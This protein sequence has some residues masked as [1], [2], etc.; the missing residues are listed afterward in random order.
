MLTE[1]I[2]ISRWNPHPRVLGSVLYLLAGAGIF[3]TLLEL[4]P[5]GFI[6]GTL[7]AALWLLALSCLEEA[8]RRDREH[9]AEQVRR[10]QE[11]DRCARC[12]RGDTVYSDWYLVAEFDARTRAEVLAVGFEP[13]RRGRGRWHRIPPGR[14]GRSWG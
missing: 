4:G 12:D 5:W 1:W 2:R 9:V 14:S 13:C 3:Y 6:S 7:S 11:A 8:D 10:S